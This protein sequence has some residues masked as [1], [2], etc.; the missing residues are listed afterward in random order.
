MMFSCDNFFCESHDSS[1]LVV[2][3]HFFCKPQTSQF[4]KECI[5]IHRT[6]YIVVG[7]G[8]NIEIKIAVFLLK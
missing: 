1:Y 7:S 2:Y 3:N 6:M 4:K 5:L 8:G